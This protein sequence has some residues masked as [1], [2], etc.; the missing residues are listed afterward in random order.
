M[1]KRKLAIQHKTVYDVVGAVRKPQ[2]DSTISA[3]SKL[4]HLHTTH[5]K[6]IWFSRERKGW[7]YKLIYEILI[8][9]QYNVVYVHKRREDGSGLG[10][11]LSPRVHIIHV[12]ALQL[13]FLH[14]WV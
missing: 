14:V 6:P 10:T 7:K 11:S 9:K 4:H 5:G 12:T 1:G 3:V 2:P 8:L 13:L